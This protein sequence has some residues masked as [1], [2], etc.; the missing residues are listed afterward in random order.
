MTADDEN[1]RDRR[2]DGPPAGDPV[3]DLLLGLAAQIDQL[4][5]LFGGGR[6][7]RSAADGPSE[8]GGFGTS[9]FAGFGNAGSAGFDTGGF[10]TG[11]GEAADAHGLGDVTG[12]I[13]TLLAEIGDLLARLIAALIA[14][15][16]A[17]AKALRS[18]P[19]DP[20]APRHYEPIAVRID[21]AGTT[22]H[23]RT[24]NPG[25]TRTPQPQPHP[26]EEN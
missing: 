12:E 11:G 16:E 22:D 6:T 25:P 24:R 20:G 17:I 15:L 26:E 4:A 10:G 13:T 18:T 14:V 9:A 3:R 8:A 7:R 21:V 23:G 19:A 5:A 1:E 2:R